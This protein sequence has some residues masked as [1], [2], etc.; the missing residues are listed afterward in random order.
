MNIPGFEGLWK[1]AEKIPESLFN[2]RESIPNEWIPGNPTEVS[3]TR[4]CTLQRLRS[5]R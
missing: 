3:D 2:T 5:A 1:L 4:R